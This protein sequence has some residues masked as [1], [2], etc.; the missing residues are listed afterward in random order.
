MNS[1]GKGKSFD[2]LRRRKRKRSTGLFDTFT[3]S[4]NI[5]ILEN[6]S[7]GKTVC[8]VQQS[9]LYPASLLYAV[10]QFSLLIIQDM[11]IIMADIH[12][13]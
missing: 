5:M 3:A 1:P 8:V 6:Q 13:S 2:E 9:A 4:F 11:I 12:S 7:G 10:S